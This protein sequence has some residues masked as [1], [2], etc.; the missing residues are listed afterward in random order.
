MQTQ[1]PYQILYL[2][3]YCADYS[4]VFVQRE[5]E[6]K[7]Q[8]TLMSMCTVVLNILSQANQLVL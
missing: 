2:A 1:M 7:V 3:K 4:L 8:M 6:S 5:P